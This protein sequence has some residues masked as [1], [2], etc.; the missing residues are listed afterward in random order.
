VSQEENAITRRTTELLWIKQ[1]GAVSRRQQVELAGYEEQDERV[2]AWLGLPV[3][4]VPASW[5][6]IV[7]AF[8]PEMMVQTHKANDYPEALSKTVSIAIFPLI[9]LLV[10]SA[11][12]AWIT[13]HLHR[14]FRRPAAGVWTTFV[15]LLG[16]PGYL[17]YL[18]EHR[19][20][21]L[22][23]CA[24]CGAVVPRDRDACANCGREFAA[25]A[26]VGTEIFA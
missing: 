23:P 17:A 2:A 26:P 25:P 18:L 20:A 15:A 21:K 4:P 1:D 5:V 7:S 22:E 16:V 3:I 10:C 6:A 9:V 24:E 13:L 19:R 11:I 8:A 14:R 12:L